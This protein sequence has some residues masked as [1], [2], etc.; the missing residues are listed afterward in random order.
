MK[1]YISLICGLVA[2]ASCSQQEPLG[3]VDNPAIYF[4]ND[5]INYSFFYAE[6]AS[7]TADVYLTVHAMGNTSAVERPFTLVQSNVGDSDAAAAGTHF[8]SLS[9]DEMK[10][11]M[12]MPAGQNEM[13]LAVT[14]LKD[15]SL[16]LTTVKLKLK[17]ADNDNFKVGVVEKDSTIITF[18]SQAIKPTNWADWY[19]AFGESWGSVKMRFIID[20]T[21]ITNFDSVPEDVYYLL[22]LNEKLKQKLYDYNVAHPDAPLAE[23]DGTLVEFDNA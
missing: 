20:N 10:K 7:A 8:L 15:A 13:K 4:D 3:Y 21:G 18:S 12:V 14:L 9:S 6:T 5:D 1:K 16:D 19:N 17:V 2:L 11:R 22:Y 23:A